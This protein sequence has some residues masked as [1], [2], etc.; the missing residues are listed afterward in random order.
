M[1]QVLASQDIPTESDDSLIDRLFAAQA[2]RPAGL[3]PV[4]VDSLDPFQRVLLVMDGTVT[5]ILEAFQGEPIEIVR[6][7]QEDRLLTADHTWLE[8]DAGETVIDRRV[9]LRGTDTG[10]G[11]VYA[12]STI[13]LSRL[14]AEVQQGLVEPGA[15]LGRLLARSGLETYRERLWYGVDVSGNDAEPRR[16]L[17]AGLLLSRTYRIFSQGRP[18]MLISEKFPR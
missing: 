2:S 18:L 17:D 10:R 12:T 4:L 11:Y 5:Q 15:G 3:E 16:C 9:L 6:L 1:R 7:G 14:P 13:V 8:A